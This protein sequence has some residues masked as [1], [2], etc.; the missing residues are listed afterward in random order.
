MIG[1]DADLVM[2]VVVLGNNVREAAEQL[3]VS[4]QVAR[5]RQQRALARLRKQLG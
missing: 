4:H 1:T 2:S 5:K 3:G